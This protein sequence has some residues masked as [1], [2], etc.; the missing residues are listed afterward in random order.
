MQGVEKRFDQGSGRIVPIVTGGGGEIGV[1]SGREASLTT[2]V[3]SPA[4]GAAPVEA[5]LQIATCSDP[6][7]EKP[8]S[9]TKAAFTRPASLSLNDPKS[10]ADRVH[11]NVPPLAMSA[12]DPMNPP[13]AAL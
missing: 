4:T 8:P 10:P 11:C 9:D 5:K 2:I 12:P 1:R 13:G 3:K 7:D 6:V